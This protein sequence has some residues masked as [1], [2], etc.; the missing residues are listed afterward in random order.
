MARQLNITIPEG[1][2]LVEDIA[3]EFPKRVSRSMHKAL[4]LVGQ[5]ATS[6]Y[7]VQTGTGGG[8]N[9][10][11][12]GVGVNATR[13]T[14]RSGALAR[15]LVRGKEAGGIREVKREGDHWTG[16]TGVRLEQVPYARRH[17]FGGTFPI[18]KKATGY[19]F[20]RFRETAEPIW[21]ALAL[22]GKKGGSIT[23]PARPFLRPAAID[24]D[25]Q[26]GMDKIISKE[27][28]NLFNRKP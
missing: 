14:L 23:T 6:K 11:G 13:L 3:R 12:V 8:S 16:T 28:E 22:K 1:K 24:P 21:L 7:M 17:E 18:T 9:K 10:A 5:I 4:T 19:F 26:R 25:T 27:M 20:H 15:A 2:E